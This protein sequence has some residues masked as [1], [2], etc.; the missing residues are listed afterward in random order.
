VELAGVGKRFQGAAALTNVSLTIARGSIHAL[1][2]E[3][4]AGKSTLGKIISGVIR[5]DTG[6]VF[7]D[8]RQVDYRSPRDALGDGIAAIQ[9]EIALVPRRSVLDNVFLGLEERRLAMVDVDLL[10]RRFAALNEETGFAL[11][12]NVLVDSLSIA[13]QQKVEIMRAL[14]REARLIV[15]D[16]PTARLSG[17]EADKLLAIVRQLQARGV[18]I[19]YVSHFL[20]E[21]LS[22]ADTVTVLRNGQ[23]IQTDPAATQTPDSL[24][25]AMLGRAA[26]LTFPA[27]V[28]PPPDAPVVLSV[29]GLTRP[30]ACHDISF[31]IRAG[32]IVGLAGLVGSGRSEV[33]RAIFGADR[34]TRGEIRLDGQRLR[35]DSPGAGVA[36]GLAMLPESRKDQGLLMR[37]PV[38]QNVTLPHLN[39]VSR[40]GVVS[41]GRE[42]RA[43]GR[44]LHQLGVRPESVTPLISRL[45][46]GN[47]QKVLFA[48]WLFE[49]P[50]VLIL[51]EP[52]R[53]VDVGAKRAIYELIASLA[54]DGLPILLI[55]SELEE[56][57]GLAHRVLVMRRGTIVAEFAGDALAEESILRAAFGSIPDADREIG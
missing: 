39:R 56:I 42:R 44:L 43:V 25:T 7:V 57:L 28:P 47:Q 32:E 19:V 4:G 31:D 5:A 24:V 6:Q 20:R 11:S 51:D 15:M 14:A 50:R 36:S 52:T 23:L 26:S 12:P 10:R 16:E 53:G 46:G 33:A 17:D 29:R 35:V 30:G 27:R 41:P 37:L 38:G 49:R 18:T 34:F 55:S 45:S 48:K 8:G 3:N 54:A 13:E 2:G 9:Q 21:V 22:I 40:A 1:V